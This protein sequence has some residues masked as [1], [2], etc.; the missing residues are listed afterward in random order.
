MVKVSLGMSINQLELDT[1]QL[2][3]KTQ[4]QNTIARHQGLAR[5]R[6]KV[7]SVT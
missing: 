3:S 2:S 5:P 1:V 7:N 6:A 4:L